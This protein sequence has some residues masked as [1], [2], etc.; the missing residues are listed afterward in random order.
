M[1]QQLEA[2]R[3]KVI[4]IYFLTLEFGAGGGDSAARRQADE[5]VFF[6]VVILLNSWMFYSS[7]LA[8]LLC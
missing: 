1:V 2:Q 7:L 3:G 6:P 8:T 5:N 4:L